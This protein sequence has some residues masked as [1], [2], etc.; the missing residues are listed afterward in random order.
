MDVNLNEKEMKMKK[1]MLYVFI[2]SNLAIA[3]GDIAPVEPVVTPLVEEN[4]AWQ[5][6]VAIY[7]WLPDLDG[8]LQ[9]SLPG[10]SGSISVPAN[11][12]VDA[13]KMTAMGTYEARKGLWSFKVDALYLNLGNT[14]KTSVSIPNGPGS[15]EVTLKADQG[16]T[17]LLLGLYGGY[18]TAMTSDYTFDLIAGARYI[19]IDVDASLSVDGPLP[20]VLPG[21]AL[22]QSEELWDAVIGFKGSY[23]LNEQWYIPY[24]FDIGAGDSDLTWQALAGVGYRY[25]WGDVLLAYRHMS[26]D[27][28]DSGLIQDLEFS[29]PAIAVK[30][31]F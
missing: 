26:Y 22:D 24:H 7:G 20:P 4:N 28:G 8:T 12:I 13:L 6:S 19:S 16:M 5:H 18:N 30:F 11:D 10:S 9:Y 25:G 17:A 2:A 23:N 31:Q 15:T 3:G 21:L 29:G 27:Q 14:E 1:T